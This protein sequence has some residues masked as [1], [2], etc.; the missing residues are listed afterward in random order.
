MIFPDTGTDGVLYL[1][2]S[3]VKI[4]Y[5]QVS[6][7]AKYQSYYIVPCSATLPAFTMLVGND[8][9]VLEGSDL[10]IPTA[11]MTNNDMLYCLSILQPGHGIVGTP[12]FDKNYVVFNQSGPS[13][14]FAPF[15]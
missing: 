10:I 1:N 8:T 4:Y 7:W 15:A 6:G 13:I 11:N 2:A 5:E 3:L 12:F 9:A 14:S